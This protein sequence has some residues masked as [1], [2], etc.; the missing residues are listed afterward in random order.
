VLAPSAPPP[1]TSS[2]S[3]ERR[4][5][6]GLTPPAYFTTSATHLSTEDPV[7]RVQALKFNVIGAAGGFNVSMAGRDNRSWQA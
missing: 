6:D 4:Q 2:A 1:I 5:P 7:L 3:T